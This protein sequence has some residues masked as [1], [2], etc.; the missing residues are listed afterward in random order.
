MVMQSPANCQ[1]GR[2]EERIS[3]IQHK[4]VEVFGEIVSSAACVELK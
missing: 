3:D 2:I 4:S 1:H